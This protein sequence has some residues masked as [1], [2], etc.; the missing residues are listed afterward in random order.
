MMSSEK[1]VL[2]QIDPVFFDLI[3]Y[4]GVVED[5]L[6]VARA[7]FD[8]SMVTDLLAV[9]G[10]ATMAAGVVPPSLDYGV[11]TVSEEIGSPRSELYGDVDGSREL[12]RKI[13]R[14]AADKLGPKAL[15]VLAP[16]IEAKSWA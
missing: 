16:L 3:A 6:E 8:W 7:G 14:V 4:L 1:V 11:V 10:K 13:L 5:V 2:G 9:L 15:P 12:M